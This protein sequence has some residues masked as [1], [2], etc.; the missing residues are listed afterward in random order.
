MQDGRFGDTHMFY[1][2]ISRMVGF[3]LDSRSN[4]PKIAKD[5]VASQFPE[6]ETYYGRFKGLAENRLSQELESMRMTEIQIVPLL[7][8]THKW[9]DEKIIPLETGRRNVLFATPIAIDTLQVGYVDAFSR[10]ISLI[11]LD[12]FERDK[13]NFKRSFDELFLKK[14]FFDIYF[15]QNRIHPEVF[16]RFIHKKDLLLNFKTYLEQEYGFKYITRLT[17]RSR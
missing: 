10:H 4:F 2:K 3:G 16:E 11:L 1:N 7:Q 9:E 15:N 5:M 14:E 12:I 13:T 17:Y 8:P 6:I